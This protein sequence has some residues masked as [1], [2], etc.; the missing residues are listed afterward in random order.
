M[1]RE[2]QRGIKGFT[3]NSESCGSR[4]HRLSVLKGRRK[5]M[6]TPVAAP[7]PSSTPSQQQTIPDTFQQLLGG[8]QNQTPTPSIIHATGLESP[9]FGGPSAPTSATAGMRNDMITVSLTPSELDE[10]NEFKQSGRKRDNA[11]LS[12]PTPSSR[13]RSSPSPSS[14]A[15]ASALPSNSNAR[16]RVAVSKSNFENRRQRRNMTGTTSDR[17]EVAIRQL[18]PLDIS[19]FSDL[20]ETD[21]L[22]FA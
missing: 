6:N 13:R 19:I 18:I 11:H 9:L 4:R 10:Y 8:G 3:N 2:G 16:K 17:D 1:P 20:M 5:S 21:H 22:Y 15:P 12:T 7:A 14:N